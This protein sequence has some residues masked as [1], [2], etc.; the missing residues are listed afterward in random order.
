MDATKAMNRVDVNASLLDWLAVHGFLCLALR[1]PGPT[2]STREIISRIV[3]RLATLVVDG[4]LLTREEMQE[5]HN[6]EQEHWRGNA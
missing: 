3:D 5:A 4:G 2:D 1:H 6:V